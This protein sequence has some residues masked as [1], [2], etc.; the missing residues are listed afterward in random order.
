MAHW[1]SESSTYQAILDEGRK[2]GREEGREEGRHEGAL[3]TLRRTLLRM[4]EAKFGPV[5]PV[6]AADIEAISDLD[7]LERLIRAILRGDSWQELRELASQ[8]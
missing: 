1:L 4:G 7:V 8:R 3:F 2:V 5:D 6:T